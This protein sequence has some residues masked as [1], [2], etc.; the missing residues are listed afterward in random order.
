[1]TDGADL[2]CRTLEDLGVDRVFGLPGTQNVQLYEAIRKSAIR[3]VLATSELAASFMANGY[4]RASGKVAPV[5]TIPGPGFTYALTGVAE[6]SQDS[7]ALLHITGK[8]QTREG[9]SYGF[10]S[11]DQ[12]SI[13]A[14]LVKGVFTIER[15]DEIPEKT[16]RA[17]A[18]AVTGEPGPVLLQWSGDALN[19][20]LARAS[21]TPPPSRAAAEVAL[22]ME[23]LVEEA[24]RF[25]GSA[26]KPILLLGQGCAE[27]AAEFA[28]LAAWLNAPVFTTIS[29]RG[30][31]PEDHE[32]SLGF[33]L[34]RSDVRLLN[35]MIRGSDCVAA[36]G[37]RLSSAG[38]GGYLL[39]LPEDRLVRVE[40][41]EEVL[42]ANYP[43]RIGI[44]GSMEA[45]LARMAPAIRRH[46][47]PAGGWAAEEIAGYR[48][49]LRVVPENAVPEPSFRGL[50][51][52]DAGALMAS[53]RRVLPRDGIVVTD[54]GLHQTLVRRHFDVLAPRGLIVPN[55]FQSMGFGIPAAIGAKIA[56][57]ER[58]VVAVTGDGC[59]AMAGMEMLTA[60]REKI[61]LTV[62]VLNDGR[63]NLIR[64]Q[65]IASSG[66]TE[67][68][69]ILNPDY[70]AF[71]A[72]V[73]ADYVCIDGNAEEV[74][75]RAVQSPGV[76]L[77]EVRAG[78][79]AAM[80]IYE[81]KGLARGLGR[82]I[83]GPG[84]VKW[85]KRKIRR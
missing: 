23:S 81:A 13:A 36:F 83:L 43:A 77:V 38:T 60:V 30:I 53:L 19:A 44:V 11:I 71:A 7:V 65:Q 64:L 85:I 82:S 49:R 48:R 29:G 1:M 45:V 51:P 3:P 27:S 70:G 16:A 73:G 34:A 69:D 17:Y 10:Q 55:D 26:R 79:S 4:Y 28:E 31:V 56:A 18:L 84:I 6:A 75:G 15:V 54:S 14:P 67:S 72:S 8:P 9:K 37:S 22:P 59:F 68:V 76:T 12:A 61:P 63:L 58:A 42:N 74:L 50:E 32:L 62:V 57:P 40:G 5:V 24:A 47:R 80:R 35:E 52:P 20:D 66:R 78:D 25:I 2:L 21:G 46:P 41:D 33:D 39:E